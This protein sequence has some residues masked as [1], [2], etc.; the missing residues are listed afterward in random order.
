MSTTFGPSELLLAYRRGVF[1]MAETRDDPN[2]FLI[3]PDER[4][5]LPLKG[6]HVPKR[7]GRTVRKAPYKVT[8]NK[9]FGR[10]IEGCAASTQNRDT[11]WINA[12]ILNLYSSMHREG[13]AHSIECWQGEELVGGL[14]GVSIG[15]AFF[16][17]SMFS[18]A[19]DASKVALVHLVARLIAGGYTLL[20]AQFH[21][22]HLDQFG[23]TVL[24]RK[25]FKKKLDQALALEADFF[26]P[27][28]PAIGQASLQ[29]ITQTS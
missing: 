17:E 18:R 23:L 20:D 29:L 5:V 9:A 7:L 19:T 3:D 8:L 15:G 14:Y 13:H 26:T 22:P 6:F 11:T 28:A 1:P 24:P 25:A 10:V 2:L 27:D 12:A 16:G 21:N 4:G